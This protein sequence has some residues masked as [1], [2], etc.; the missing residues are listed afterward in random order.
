MG[1]MK[2]LKFPDGYAAG[3]RQSVNMMTWKI[4]GLKSHD[5]HIIMER[6]LSVMFRGYFDDAVWMVLAELSYVLKKSR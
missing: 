6:F 4:I 1:W 2:G 5:Y 3:L